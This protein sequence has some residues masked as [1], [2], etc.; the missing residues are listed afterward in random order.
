VNA[1]ITS[2]SSASVTC[3]AC[4]RAIFN[5]IMTRERISRSI[6]IVHDLVPY[7]YPSQAI[8]LLPSRRWAGYIIAMSVEPRK[9]CAK[10][11]FEQGQL[12]KTHDPLRQEA[13]T[14]T[15]PRLPRQRL[16]SIAKHNLQATEPLNPQYGQFRLLAG[17][18]STKLL[19]ALGILHGRRMI[20]LSVMTR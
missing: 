20:E 1:W 5:I 2:L 14:A 6:R 8:T 18:H 7:S 17:S 19:N 15:A 4:C 3:A 16:R 9:Y 11:N 13:I 10:L 12:R